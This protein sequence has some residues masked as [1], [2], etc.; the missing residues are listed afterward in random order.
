MALQEHTLAL[1]SLAWARALGLPD[2]GLG[3][4]SATPASGTASPMGPLGPAAAGGPPGT[5]TAPGAARRVEVVLGPEDVLPGDGERVATVL[6]LGE[7]AVVAGPEWFVTAC[8]DVD[9]EVL[10]LESTLLRI[11]A[12]HGA[13]S[14]GEHTLYYADEAPAVDPAQSIAVSFDSAHALEVGALCPADDVTAAALPQWDHTAALVPVFADSQG[15]GVACAAAGHDVLSG[16]VARL[17]VLAVPHLRGKG[18]GTYAAA[19]AMESAWLDGLVPSAR[20]PEGHTQAHH[21]AVAVGMEP[22][23]TQTSIEWGANA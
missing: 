10:A 7:A 17:G 23:G 14:R 21:I 11:G 19:A 6:R 13:R 20:V 5:P 22:L 4:L 3:T 1:I 16:I 8:R 12:G 9:D 18:L 2:D 15:G